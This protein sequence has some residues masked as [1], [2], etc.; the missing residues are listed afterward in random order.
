M[1]TAN[2]NQREFTINNASVSESQQNL[3]REDEEH[4]EDGPYKLDTRVRERS[5]KS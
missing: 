5:T 2:P 3:I 4:D 1:T